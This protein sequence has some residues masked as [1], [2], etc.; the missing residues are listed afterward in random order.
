MELAA[1]HAQSTGSYL[2]WNQLDRMSVSERLFKCWQWV[3]GLHG[4]V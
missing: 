1:S 3:Q 2:E 4:Y